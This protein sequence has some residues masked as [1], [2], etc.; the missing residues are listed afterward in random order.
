MSTETEL[1]DGFGLQTT[2]QQHG[3]LNAPQHSRVLRVLQE[4]AARWKDRGRG[5]EK[6]TTGDTL[7]GG[8]SADSIGR[9]EAETIRDM[10]D[11]ILEVHGDPPGRKADGVCR[12]IYENINGLPNRMAGNHKLDRARE[13]IHKLEAD[14]V[15]FNEHKT[16]LSSRKNVNGFR[17]LFQGGETELR[18]I[19]AHNAHSNVGKRQEG[20]TCLLAIGSLLGHYDPDSSGKD[21]SGLGRW[22][23]MTFK[24]RDGFVTRVV[25]G[26]NPCYSSKKA[27]TSTA[28]QLQRNYWLSVKKQTTCPRTKFRQ[29]LIALL[30]TWRE[31]GDRIVVCMDANE[32]IYKK[33]IGKLLTDPDGLAMNETVGDFTGQMIGPTYFR[34][35]RPIDAIWSTSDLE[36]VGACIMPCGYG[37]GDH[38][39]FVVDFLTSSWVGDE[40]LKIVR[41]AARRLNTRIPT[42]AEA[43][44]TELEQLITRHRLIERVGAVYNSGRSRRWMQ[45]AM[46]AIDKEGGQYMLGAENRCRKVRSGVIPF[47]PEA[48][49]W[50]RRA[51][52][53]RSLLTWKLGKRRNMGNLRRLAKRVDIQDPFR[54]STQELTKR[55]R[56]CEDKCTALKRTGWLAR[57]RFLRER[58]QQAQQR[59][60]FETTEKILAI[61]KREKD[62][63]FWGR[64]RFA[65]GKKRGRSVSTVQIEQ[66]DGSIEEHTTQESVENAIFSEI[67]RKRFFLAEDAPICRGDLRESFGYRS[68]TET[69]QAVLDGTFIYPSDFDEP[70]KLLCQSCTRIRASIPKNSVSSIIRHGE[71]GHK[72]ARSKEDTSSSESGQ[73]FGHQKAGAS[74]EII[75]HYHAVK[76]SAIMMKVLSLERWSR[77]LSVMIKKVAGCTMISK[78]RSILLMEADFNFANKCIYGVRMLDTVRKHG[79]MPEEIFSEKNRMADDGTLTKM[80]FYDISRQSKRPAAVASVDADNC[81]DRISHAMASLC[82]QAFGVSTEAVET[83]LGTIEDMKFFLRTA[84][85]DST[86]F[87]G[88]SVHM[89]TQGLCQ[90]NG[91]APAGWA[92]VSIVILD[93][94]KQE[95]H[96]ATFRCP[97]SRRAKKISAILFV[98][99]TDLLHINMEEREILEETHDAMQSSVSSWGTKL[100]A[101]GGA[102]KPPKCFYYLIDYDW[103]ED[104]EWRY[105]ELTE[106]ELVKYEIRVPTPSGATVQIECLSVNDSRKTLGSMTCPSGEAKSALDRMLTQTQEWVDTAKNSSLH[107]RYVLFL[108]QRQLWPRVGFALGC[109]MASAA[110]L[111]AV[112]MKPYYN[113]LPLAGVIRSAPKDLRMLDIAFG[114]IGFPHPTVETL[115]EQ[116]NKL[117]MHYGCTSALGTVLQTSME[118]FVLELGLSSTTPFSFSYQK[119]EALVTRC[120]LKTI[121]EKCDRYNIRVKVGNI[122]IH[123]P[124]DGDKW[125]IQAFIDDG[126]KD[127]ELRWL[128]RVR[129]H[130]QALFLSDVLNANGRSIDLKYTEERAGVPWSSYTFPTVYPSEAD[131]ELWRSAIYGVSPASR[132]RLRV[133]DFRCPGH[134]IWDWR[135]IEEEERLLF[136]SPLSGLVDVYRPSTLPGALGRANRWQLVLVDQVSLFRGS[137]CSIKQIAEEVVAMQGHAPEPEE[138]PRP[139]NFIDFLMDAEGKWMWDDLTVTGD[140]DWV[141][142]AIRNST[143]R[144]VTDG[145][146]M[147]ELFLDVCSVAFILESTEG[148]GTITGSFTEQ[149]S[150]AC[151]YRGEMLGLMAIHL[152]LAGVASTVTDLEQGAVEIHSDCKGALGMVEHIPSPRIPSRC[153]HSDVL[154]NILVN[155]ANLPF[156]CTFH[157]VKAHQDD[158][159]PFHLL[160]R[161]SQLNVMMDTKAKAAL[162]SL[163]DDTPRPQKELP[164]EAI[165]IYAGG[166]K[167]TSDC[168]GVVRAW[169][170]RKHAKSYFAEKLILSH[171]G[172]E[173]VDWKNYSA[174]A[175]SVPRLFQLWLCKQTMSIAATNKARARFTKDLSPLCPSCK[176]EEE[177]CAH[178]ITCQEVGRV[179]ALEASIG[180]LDTWM[181]ETYT[182]PNLRF[183]IISYAKSRGCAP[184]YDI[185]R[186]M[187]PRVRA[188]GRAQDDIG[189]RRFMEGMVALPMRAIQLEFWKRNNW[190]GNVDKWIHTDD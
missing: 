189:W 46:N 143:V 83:M 5:I 186:F 142:E 58:C 59:Q 30:T 148:K 35:S 48:V 108:I 74:S 81:F 106:E 15:A 10:E 127:D 16:N 134:K 179:A 187:D 43:Y 133:R 20:G 34:G 29:D 176:V 64:L 68:N 113:L 128:N 80:L 62:R 185:C 37:V 76:A 160:D 2:V 88:S 96:G 102:L 95:K 125:L 173:Q 94:H 154:K 104:G 157:H 63:A 150:E 91:A 137:L 8:E 54:L 153:K 13:M 139:R 19:A 159:T 97:I 184:M 51:Q 87:A 56:V 55:L 85:G 57:R 161:P 175:H 84:Y 169:A 67:H 132:P 79:W 111:D 112:L 131:L 162:Q 28:Y 135:Y 172:F 44:R 183:A 107:K 145:S 152:I 170:H 165:S 122:N 140:E 12:L 115:V 100:S 4:R 121:W 168:S 129:I 33:S 151:A 177:T 117:A 60:D 171:E 156:D 42:A 7:V 136:R 24:G 9:E 32:H 103:D 118:L 190:R 114:G 90:G 6:D 39:V 110:Q 40:P 49:R 167:I 38:R 99:D 75:S 69:A 17:K 23:F 45:A 178:V 78:L 188:M 130:Q 73:H 158:S 11:E 123:P 109:N 180:L 26:Y 3:H 41:P 27:G 77:G 141:V 71:W 105:H 47:S 164:L 21:E 72:W 166:D 36:V 53:Y 66:W 65:M 31:Q 119:Y 93:A 146:Y 116:L 155:C 149:S 22:T 138:P 25:C 126:Y 61:I 181:E 101:S 18:A 163:H 1:I 70:T 52:V 14:V 86:L 89:K 98:D 120:W 174:V 50:L 182:D 82:F 124:R 144:A 147:D 92:V